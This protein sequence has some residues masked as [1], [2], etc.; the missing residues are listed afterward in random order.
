[1]S[2][3][4]ILK[5]RLI[6]SGGDTE[7]RMTQGKNKTLLNALNNSY[8]AEI[9]YKGQV[10]HKALIN[11]NKLKMDYDDKVISIPFAE[12]FKVGDVFFWPKTDE[13]WIVYLRQYSEDAY[14]R[15]FIRKALHKIRWKNSFGKE[16]E[17]FAAVRGPVETK[18][19]S[20][21]KSGISFDMPN[22]SLSIIVPNDEATKDLK[23]Y[24]KVSVCGKIW[25]VLV[26][27]NI[28][29]PGVIDLQL[30]ESYI[31]NST[32]NPELPGGKEEM[33]IEVTTSLDGVEILEKD[34]NFHIWTMVEKDGKTS[35]ELIENAKFTVISG[36]AS[37]TKTQLTPLESGPLVIELSIEKSGYSKLFTLNVK[38]EVLPPSLAYEILGDEKVK[39]F[40]S[41]S[42]SIRHFMDGLIVDDINGNWVITDNNSLFTV[43]SKNNT[44]IILKWK[45]GMKGKFT[46]DYEIDGVN[47]AS[48]NIIV[49]SL[50]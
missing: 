1:M 39:S 12:N 49:E 48:K 29:E 43:T 32:D 9:I 6:V 19:K 10:E 24:A 7:G 25:E 35:E 42:Y 17:T 20:E 41:T 46:I 22:Y 26:A 5:K 37:L 13:H 34:E 15:G 45:V 23:R 27:D 44:E 4:D 18:I 30:I 16:M 28:S 33:D 31:N 38:E 50:I 40:G 47:V 14:F 3:L 8:Q 21:M 2:S 36:T 11:N